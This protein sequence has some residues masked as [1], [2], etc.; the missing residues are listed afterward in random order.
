MLLSG[1]WQMKNRKVS[2]LHDYHTVCVLIADKPKLAWRI[3]RRGCY[4]NSCCCGS[5]ICRPDSDTFSGAGFTLPIMPPV[6]AFTVFL[7]IPII[8][9]L[10]ANQNIMAQFF[11]PTADGL[12]NYRLSL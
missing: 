8:D 9:A 5:S 4:R 12:M 2:L 6:L 1:V 11:G 7:F 3:N 10:R